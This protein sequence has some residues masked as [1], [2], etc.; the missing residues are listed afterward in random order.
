MDGGVWDGH[1]LVVPLS[2]SLP[3]LYTSQTRWTKPAFR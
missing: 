3:L 2:Y 1:R